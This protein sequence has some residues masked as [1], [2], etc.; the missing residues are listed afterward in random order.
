MHLS[1][2]NYGTGGE[3]LC[4]GYCDGAGTPDYADAC[5][6]DP[7][8]DSDDDNDGDPD[9][10]DCAPSDPS[11]FHGAKEL[12]NGIDENCNDIY[13]GEENLTMACGVSDVGLCTFGT[14]SCSNSGEWNECS[15]VFPADEIFDNGLDEDC[16]GTD[17]PA[18]CRIISP[19]GDFFTKRSLQIFFMCNQTYDK[20]EYTMDGRY[21][22]TLCKNCYFYKGLKSFRDNENN[23]VITTRKGQEVSEYY[24]NFT[25]DV[26]PPKLQ[27]IEP[28]RGFA[29]DK[30]TV[31]YTEENC[32]SLSLKIQGQ[33][34]SVNQTRACQSG[35]NIEQEFVFNLSHFEGRIVD[36]IASVTDINGGS[37]TK[38]AKHLAVDTLPP[39]ILSV[40]TTQQGRYTYWK[41]QLDDKAK[42]LWYVNLDTGKK[43]ILCS[44]CNDYGISSQRKEYIKP[45]TYHYS[46]TAEDSAGNQD[47]FSPLALS[48]V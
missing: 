31:K 47:T 8:C 9:V 3:Y 6:Y 42:Y 29:I 34:D 46:F 33:F 18:P 12:C 48:V 32:M 23:L 28:S 45:G 17:T 14:E 37:D 16:D 35:K 4:R 38:V 10:T 26:R 1:D 15:A 20:I 27:R 11:R 36:A 43:K 41:I 39:H 30:F 5:I 19:I 21:L 25:V 2:N 13:D 7:F 24:S 40:N 44:W 22:R